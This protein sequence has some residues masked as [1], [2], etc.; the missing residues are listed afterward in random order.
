[1][2][3]TRS[4]NTVLNCKIQ[5]KNEKVKYSTHGGLVVRAE[6]RVMVDRG[7]GGGGGGE[8]AELRHEGETDR[9]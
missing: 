9:E 2:A 7:E 6:V 5:N 1:M 8:K 3:Q 4:L